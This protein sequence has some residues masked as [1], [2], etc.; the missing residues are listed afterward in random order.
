MLKRVSVLASLTFALSTLVATDVGA[1]QR[2]FVSTKGINNPD[3]SLIAPCRDFASAIAASSVGGEVIVLDSGGYGPVTITQSASIV[4]PDGV[5]AGITVFSGNGVTIGTAGVA[6]TLKGL[7][8]N[9]LG[10]ANGILMTGGASLRV[11]R[12]AVSGFMA[13]ATAGINIGSASKVFISDTFVS[14]NNVGIVLDGGANVE[15][16]RVNVVGNVNTGILMAGTSNATTSAVVTETR[17]FGNGICGLQALGQST[18]TGG[19]FGAC[20]SCTRIMTVSGST[21]SNN[22]SG[23]CQK[24]PGAIVTVGSSVASKNQSYGLEKGIGGT[25]RSAQDNVSVDNGSAPTSGPSTTS[26]VRF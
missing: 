21:A 5:Y 20:T 24:G 12:C 10:G 22:N 16:A 15:I 23:F 1:A 14:Q 6:V 11:E 26:G 18:S 7:T 19:G 9:G 25:L 13:S 8:I 3:C 4:A 17:A 2:T